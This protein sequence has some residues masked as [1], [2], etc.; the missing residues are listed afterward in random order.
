MT[1]RSEN[2]EFAAP[3]YLRRREGEAISEEE[4]H[5]IHWVSNTLACYLTAFGPEFDEA[6]ARL[7]EISKDAGIVEDALRVKRGQHPNHF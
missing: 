7:R 3:A 4:A 5:C 2:M 6:A 1:I